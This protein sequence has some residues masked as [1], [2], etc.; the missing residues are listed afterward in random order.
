MKKLFDVIGVI[1]SIWCVY[2][3][4]IE[5]FVDLPSWSLITPIIML[6]ASCLYS[7]WKERGSN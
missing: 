5:L 2:W 6:L 7:N 4:M 3:F 1:G